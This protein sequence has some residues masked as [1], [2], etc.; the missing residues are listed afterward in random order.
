MSLLHVL[1]GNDSEVLDGKVMTTGASLDTV[2][3]ISTLGFD[4][5]FIHWHQTGTR[6]FVLAQ[7]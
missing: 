2:K 4:E 5:D 1:K 7:H 3:F 6:T